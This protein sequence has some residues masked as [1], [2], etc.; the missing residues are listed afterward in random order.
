MANQQS[1]DREIEQLQALTQKAVAYLLGVTPRRV[2]DYK[3]LPRNSD[4]T[5][6]G[7]QLLEWYATRNSS[8]DLTSGPVTDNLDR[9][10]SVQADI[11]TVELQKL[12]GAF[13]A[14]RDAVAMIQHTLGHIRRGIENSQR[15]HGNEPIDPVLE[16]WH[17]A[18]DELK[19]WIESKGV[20]GDE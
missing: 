15:L 20:P 14:T 7:K 4:G 9:L 19:R 13:V 1:A 3:D 11:K 6:D 10:R 12:R 2:R 8:G 17:T 5:Y 16:G 18:L